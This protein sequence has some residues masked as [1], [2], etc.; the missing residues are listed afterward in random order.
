[1]QKRAVLVHRLRTQHPSDHLQTRRTKLGY[2]TA[3]D[4]WIWVLK[5]DNN[6]RHPSSNHSLTARGCS[7]VVAARLECDD[8][9]PIPGRSSGL[10]QRTDLGMGLAGTSMKP[11]TDQMAL[12]I[13][14]QG[15]NKR[16]GTGVAISQRRQ[17]KGT[18]H[19]AGPHQ[20]SGSVCK[21]RHSP[22][23]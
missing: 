10:G 7:A 23:T 18:A 16:I 11:F 17:V 19:P 2:T 22:T 20:L 15:P 13:E 4:P 21:E 5:R 12:G 14:N 6:A 9:R 3:G 1:M 8:Q